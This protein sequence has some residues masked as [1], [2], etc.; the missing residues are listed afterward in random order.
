VTQYGM[1]I[2]AAQVAESYC[3]QRLQGGR[4]CRERTRAL[5]TLI[6][7]YVVCVVFVC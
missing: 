4:C 1:G 5:L 3:Q 7:R 2:A 6:E